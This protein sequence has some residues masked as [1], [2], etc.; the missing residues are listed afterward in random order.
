MPATGAAQVPRAMD[1]NLTLAKAMG[2]KRGYDPMPPD[3]HEW[4]RAEGEPP[5]YR[6]WSW[7]CGHTIRL[8]YRSAYAVDAVGKSLG[9]KDAAK[10]LDLDLGQLSKVWKQGEEAGLWRRSG[11]ELHLNGGV[12]AAQVLGA[13]AK[14]QLDCTVNLSQADLLKIQDWP[15]EKQK[16]FRAAWDPAQEYRSKLEAQKIA[17]ARAACDEIED[18]IRRAFSLEKKRMPKRRL[19]GLEFP[20]ALLPFVQSTTVPSNGH[21]RTVGENEGENVTVRAAPSLL[22]SEKR[23]RGESVGRSSASGPE[24]AA[25]RTTD[26]PVPLERENAIRKLLLEEAGAILPGETPG[27]ALCALVNAALGETPL[28]YLRTRIQSAIGRGKYRSMGLA[29]HLASEAAAGWAAGEAAREKSDRERRAQ[30][31]EAWADMERLAREVLADP[32][33]SPEDKQQAREILGQRQKG[34]AT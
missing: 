12:T 2:S 19:E 27:P 4:Q 16:E 18:T 24:K 14:R 15:S 13:R 9:L 5:L 33:A 28:S 23:Q 29:V 30:E 10:D 7:M 25:D 11:A 32:R 34:A 26:K 6:L 3:Q 8:G 1:P 31:A 17:E 22:P 20:Q 21:E